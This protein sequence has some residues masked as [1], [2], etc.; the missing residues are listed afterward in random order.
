MSCTSAS[1][2]VAVGATGDVFT[3]NGGSWSA[4]QAVDNGSAFSGVS[5][6]SPGFCVAV[7][8]DGMAAAFTDG[9]WAISAIGV[10]ADAIACPSD[11][12]CVAVNSSGGALVYRGGHW[13]PVTNIDGDTAVEAVSCPSHGQLHRDRQYGQRHVLLLRS[14]GR[15][16]TPPFPRGGRYLAPA[17]MLF[18]QETTNRAEEP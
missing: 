12:Y 6:S 13:S 14:G 3:Y 4:G 9:R 15:A 1:N 11:G 17:V 5:C 18:R 2:C 7:D 8:R 16:D 10:V